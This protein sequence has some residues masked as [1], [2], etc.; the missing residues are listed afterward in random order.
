MQYPN[1]LTYQAYSIGYCPGCGIHYRIMKLSDYQGNH[2]IVT[3]YI[4][5]YMNT[6][7]RNWNLH[8]REI[9]NC[10][11]RPV[12]NSM[13][14]LVP[15]SEKKVPSRPVVISFIY[16]AVPVPSRQFSFTVPSRHEKQKV[17]VLHRPIPSRN[18]TPSV[19]SCPIQPTIFFI[20]LRSRP[21]FHFFPRQTY[22]N[23]P[24]SSH[25]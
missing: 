3:E 8:F 2:E 21:V 23:S 11:S 20:I 25:L 16:R 17:S 6:Y 22:Q 5:I 18:F 19:P 15:S 12:V 9:R 7:I 13:Y 10:T 14:R 1:L 24:V 4:Y